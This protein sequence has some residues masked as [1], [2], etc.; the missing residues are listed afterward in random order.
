MRMRAAAVRVPGLGLFREQRPHHAGRMVRPGRA[1]AVTRWHAR[2]LSEGA[3]AALDRPPVADDGPAVLR[4]LVVGPDPLRVLLFGSGPLIGYGVRTRKDAVDA[5]LAQL[6]A[7]STGRGVIVESRVRLSLPVAEAVRSL[8]GAGTATFAVAVWAPRFGEELLYSDPERCR[9]SIETMLR[10]FR[11]QSAIPLVIC[12]LPDPL[13]FDW[14]TLLRRPRV[15]G[16]NRIVT[17][18]ASSVPG[19]TAVAIGTYRP[20]D[21][22]STPAPWHRALAE[23]LAPAVLEA[24]RT[25]PLTA[26]TIAAASRK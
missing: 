14:R 9:S 6:L 7:D 13:G 25:P 20:T 2:R 18:A 17:E 21:A 11:A 22:A 8:G 4:S 23:H 1:S 12:H 15:A 26:A 3:R 19:V 10:Q 16:F 5:P 24:L